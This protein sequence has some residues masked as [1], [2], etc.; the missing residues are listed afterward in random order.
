MAR[1]QTIIIFPH[2]NDGGGDISKA[3]YVEWKYRIPGESKQ[4]KERVYKGLNKGSAKERYDLA[5]KIIEEKTAWLQSGKH[6]NGNVT[7][8][9]E[10]E[11]MYRH[12]AKLY[13]KAKEHVVTI[14]TFLSDFLALKREQVNKKTLENYKSK[15]R[16]FDN[17]LLR[18]NLHDTHI[19]NITKRH[20]TDFSI[21]LS[22]D[23][24]YSRRT[25]K[26]YIQILHSFFEFEVDNNRLENNP[27]QKIPEAGRVIDCSAVPFHLDE[28]KR[29]KNA[30][31][32][33]DPQLWLACEMQYYCALRPG[34]ELRLMR[35]GWIDFERKKIR[36]PAEE[37][38]SNR[39]DII[40][41]PDLLLKSL[42][43]YRQYDKSLYLFGKFNRPNTE[44]VG[45]NTLRNRFNYYRDELGISKDRK[46]YSWKHTGGIQLM[47]N[48]AKP[49][50]L[51]N[52][53]RH[54]SFATTEG[55]LKKRAGG[56]DS[57]ITK[58]SSE[59]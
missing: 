5:K 22:K 38:K 36:I 58:F 43:P 33:K 45:K 3:W 39:T 59:I 25:I 49:Y 29:L 26:K 12:E 19:K 34:V 37:A 23:L 8:V 53:F 11:L 13:G 56:I 41:I 10:D 14:R 7:R 9:Y 32:R 46:F 16:T 48:G 47:D 44:P 52:H 50:D 17:W 1:K 21:H 51:Q 28:R 57:N 40:D 24:N 18:S 27:V 4:R 55:Y 31:E 42:E 30:I 20:I 35:I 2:L 15:L 6:L 54:K